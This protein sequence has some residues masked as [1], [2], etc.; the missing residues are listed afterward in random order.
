MIIPMS[1]YRPFRIV[2]TLTLL[3]VL[4]LYSFALVVR[5]AH[6]QGTGGTPLETAIDNILTSVKTAVAR[7]APAVAFISFIVLGLMYMGS[8][9][10]VIKDWKEQNPRAFSN[11]MLGIGV[12]L[13]ASTIS[14]VLT[15]LPT[16]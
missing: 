5:P 1:A 3:A 2:L 13:L 6:A 4:L 7:F 11:V 10:P 9:I 12:V 16:Q 14:G 8:S 15:N